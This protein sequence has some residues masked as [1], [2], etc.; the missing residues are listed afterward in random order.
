MFKSRLYSNVNVEFEFFPVGR[1]GGMGY[2][3]E[4]VKPKI[5]ELKKLTERTMSHNC[6]SVIQWETCIAEIANRI[7]DLPLEMGNLV[8]EFEAVNLITPN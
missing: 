1:E 7:N 8:S 5:Q 3:H 2:M 6:L 4:K